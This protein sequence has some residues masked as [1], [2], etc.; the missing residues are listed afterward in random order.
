MPRLA[1]ERGV[2]MFANVSDHILIPIEYTSLA[3]GIVSFPG[4]FGPVGNSTN[5][6]KIRNFAI[7]S[8]AYEALLS[9]IKVV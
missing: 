7:V 6:E 8:A 4:G 5:M 9:F 1:K 2:K 3:A